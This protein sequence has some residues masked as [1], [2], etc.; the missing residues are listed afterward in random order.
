MITITLSEEQSKILFTV[1]HDLFYTNRCT[2]DTEDYMTNRVVDSLM[3]KIEQA[4]L[5]SVS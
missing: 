2:V 3:Y 5:D 4:R 1:L